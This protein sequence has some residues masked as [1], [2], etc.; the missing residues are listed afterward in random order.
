M[1]KAQK[2]H[3]LVLH[4]FTLSALLAAPPANDSFS[5]RT[6]VEGSRV[7]MAGSFLGATL[8]A[9]EPTTYGGDASVW[10]SWVAPESGLVLVE[11]DSGWGTV[12]VST[13][14]SVENIAAP[15]EVVT[16]MPIAPKRYATFQAVAGKEYKVGA[17]GVTTN[18][19]GFQLSLSVTNPPIILAGPAS[20]RISPGGSAFFTVAVAVVGSGRARIQWQF[21]GA[22]LPNETSSILVRTNATAAMAGEYRAIVSHTDSVG[23]LTVRTSSVARLTVSIP[24]S[25]R[26]LVNEDPS[27]AGVLWISVVGEPERLYSF[28]FFRSLPGH[29][30]SGQAFFSSDFPMR[31]PA[32]QSQ[33]FFHLKAFEPSN[34][35]CWLN[36][37]RIYFSKQ[38]VA[39]DLKMSSEAEFA[40]SLVQDRLGLVPQ[41]PEGGTYMYNSIESYPACSLAHH[42]IGHKIGD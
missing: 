33:L 5:N 31:L 34:P 11:S 36:L 14:T 40:P 22:D 3:Y 9:G 38:R 21:E 41:C 12:C 27:E 19:D 42:A 24:Q 15:G 4:L 39:A 30:Y 29:G 1:R 7:A 37:Q 2:Y 16:T 35:T 13:A 25:P 17:F 10:W 28:G 23:N 8:E 20:Q 18:P 6:R 26:L 32:D